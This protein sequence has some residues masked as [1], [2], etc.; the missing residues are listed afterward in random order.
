[1]GGWYAALKEGTEVTKNVL[2][3]SV[4]IPGRTLDD[5][6]QKSGWGT[7]LTVCRRKREDTGIWLP[8]RP[9]W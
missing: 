3:A 6:G 8:K 1:M 2:G 9:V 5:T 4:T 7:H